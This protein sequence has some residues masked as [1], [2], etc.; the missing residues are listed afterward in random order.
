MRRMKVLIDVVSKHF[1]LLICRFEFPY[2]GKLKFLR[3]SIKII[4]I[5]EI[6]LNTIHYEGLW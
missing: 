2:K 3:V 5:T 4:E 6:K 1:V